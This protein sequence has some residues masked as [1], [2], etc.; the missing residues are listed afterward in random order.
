MVSTIDYGGWIEITEVGGDT[1][2][3]LC[4]SQPDEG[5]ED[6][7]ATW[8][9]YPGGATGW[10]LGTR[11]RVVKLKNLW[12]ETTAHKDAFIGFLDGGQTAGFTLRIKISSGGAYWL[13]DGTN[14][15]MPC[16]WDKTRGIKKLYGGDSTIWVIGELN[17]RANGAL[18]ATP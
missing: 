18:S 11:K 13:W 17:L 8:L 10:S 4:E 3:V 5:M 14:D 15:I 12:F 9:E 2:K 16:M 6:P 1:Y 7:S